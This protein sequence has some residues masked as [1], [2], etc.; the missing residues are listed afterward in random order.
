MFEQGSPF[1]EITSHN[2]YELAFLVVARERLKFTKVLHVVVFVFSGIIVVVRLCFRSV[3]LGFALVA[4]E[5]GS[6]GSRVAFPEQAYTAGLS[7]KVT[8]NTSDDCSAYRYGGGGWGPAVLDVGHDKRGRC[9]GADTYVWAANV[10]DGVW[11]S[12]LVSSRL[13]VDVE[14]STGLSDGKQTGAREIARRNG[15]AT[16]GTVNV[17]R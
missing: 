17:S 8:G 5:T 2:K 12:C 6:R 15:V 13:A 1:T 3:W 10:C 9:S 7:Q 4:A 16:D 14:L 11:S